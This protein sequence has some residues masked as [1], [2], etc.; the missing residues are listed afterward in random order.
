MCSKDK[1]RKRREVKGKSKEQSE[2]VRKW[3]MGRKKM[4]GGGE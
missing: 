4:E 3:E 1:K 2:E